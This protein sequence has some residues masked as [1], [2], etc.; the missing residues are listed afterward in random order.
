MSE[1]E[2]K[3]GAPKIVDDSELPHSSGPSELDRGLVRTFRFLTR[4]F[5]DYYKSS[6]VP[7]PPRLS[8]R[9]YAFTF[10]GKNFM[11][12]HTAFRHRDELQRFLNLRVPSSVYYSTAYYR[13]PGAGTMGEKD[14]LGADLIFDLDAD[15]IPGAEKLSFEDMLARVKQEFE[16]LIY[17][18]LIQD[19]GFKEKDIE[20]VFSG[21]RGYHIHITRQDVL[22]LTSHQRR[23]IVDYITGKGLDLEKFLVKKAIGIR[24]PGSRYSQTTYTY[25]LPGMDEG[26]WRGKITR[27]VGEVARSFDDRED[28]IKRLTGLKGVGKK[29][30]E[31]VVAELYDSP[32][33]KE[34]FEALKEGIVDVFSSDRILNAFIKLA[35]QE[36]AINLGGETDEPVTAD[37]KRLIRLP[38]SLHGKTGFRVVPLSLGELENFDPLTDS[39]VLSDRPIEFEVKK[40]IE[41]RVGAEEFS[42]TAGEKVEVPAYLAAFLAGRKAGFIQL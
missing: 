31:S 19:F 26:G 37:I 14:W 39:I 7:S 18:Y 29:T 13:T 2:Q 40:S 33:G 23:E 22:A 5:R 3:T 41:G 36:S 1:S 21:G 17:D 28:A 12:R 10:F 15:H 11:L 25:R 4:E 16:K 30:A 6:K 32:A 27:G 9:E 24:N 35:L 38:G 8:R 42:F 20:V 34:K